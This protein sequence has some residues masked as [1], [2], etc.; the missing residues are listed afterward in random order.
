MQK[1]VFRHWS[2]IHYVGRPYT[3]DDPLVALTRPGKSTVLISNES[4][5]GGLKSFYATSTQW[6]Q[7][8]REQ[9]GR[10]A[11]MFP[12]ARPLLSFRRHDAWLL[13]LYK[14]YLKY[15]GNRRLEQFFDIEDNTG[16]LQHA[17]L[18]QAERLNWV[19]EC[20]A[21]EPFVFFCEELGE[22]L[23]P[24]LGELALLFGTEIPRLGQR[25][26]TRY[27][28]GVNAAQSERLIATNR[29]LYR[30]SRRG[31][32]RR[33]VR[34]FHGIAYRVSGFSRE[35]LQLPTSYREF[36]DATYRDDWQTVVDFATRSRGLSDR[37]LQVIN[38]RGKRV[39]W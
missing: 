15:G 2:G 13:S 17:D 11:E 16:V 26:H 14:H 1:A 19:Q 33:L 31:V 25:I 5:S 20:F 3:D 36:I 32:A 7:R 18:M 4:L 34:F 28:E 12:H 29:L 38:G 23:Q 22:G 21:I 8:Q 39:S 9:I 6:S 35:P 27:N 37:Q 10:V 24:L 30:L